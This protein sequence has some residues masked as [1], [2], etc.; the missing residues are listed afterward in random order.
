MFR[1]LTLTQRLTD[2]LRTWL[3]R[4]I[5]D[6]TPLSS[7]TSSPTGI[8]ATKEPNQP[9]SNCILVVTRQDCLQIILTILTEPTSHHSPLAQLTIGP[10]V[11]VGRPIGN[12]A[13]GVVRIWWEEGGQVGE[14]SGMGPG[15]QAMGRLDSWGVGDHLLDA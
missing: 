9:Q 1:L 15:L 11:D 12:T 5:A 4:L 14:D 10:E 7:P 2:R 6:H 8:P 3:H 13:V